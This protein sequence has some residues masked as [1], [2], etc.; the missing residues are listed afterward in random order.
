MTA[1]DE[2]EYPGQVFPQTHPNRLAVIAMLHGLKPAHPA[3]CRVLEVGCGDGINLLALALGSP[4]STF[5]GFDLAARPIEQGRAM[6]AELDLTNVELTCADLMDYRAD[7]PFDYII[8]HGFLSW[9]PDFVRERLFQL[10][11]EAL[12]PGGVAFIS[13][14]TYPGFHARRMLGEMMKIH[15]AAATTPR[16]RIDGARGLV[17]F[18]LAGQN[19]PDEFSALLRKEAEWVMNRGSEA[20]LIHD[21]LAEINQPYYVHEFAA[22]AAAHGLRFLAEAD[23]HEMNTGYFP[24]AVAQALDAMPGVLQREQYIDFLKCRRFRQTLLVP[25]ERTV[26]AAP[27]PVTVKA[28]FIASP[29][30]PESQ[31]LDLSPQV[32]ESFLAPRGGALKIDHALTKAALLV[33]NSLWPRPVPFD[34]LVA[35]AK[36]LLEGNADADD[37]DALAQVLLQAFRAGVV[38]LHAYRPHWTTDIGE[39]PVASPLLRLQLR[40]GRDN[41]ASLRPINMLVD[42][43]LYRELFL[44]LDGARDRAALEHELRAAIESGAAALPEGAA[45]EQLPEV[46]EAA[47]RKAATEAVLIG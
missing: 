39:R 27:D 40:L 20:L 8:A 4:D 44:R 10:C 29:I 21:D 3:C 26:E 12:A 15:T 23:Y 45:L 14:N 22:L 33:M 32:V 7:A 37:E 11:R 36:Q 6:A 46:I 16:E 17:Q 5:V 18:L 31:R 1:Y 25:A 35:G 13:Y 34:E 9:V 41:V 30:K 19:R 47:L 42:M 24:P 28:M 43:P 2:F 38:D